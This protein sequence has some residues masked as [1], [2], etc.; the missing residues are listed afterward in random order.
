[1]SISPCP[2][3][4]QPLSIMATHCPH[5]ARPGRYP[6]V[7]MASQAADVAAL[8]DRVQKAEARASA[9]GAAVN[10]Q[11]FSA[12][13]AG[14]KAV[15]ARPR[16][17][18]ERLASNDNQIYATYYQLIEA[19][20]RVPDDDRWDALRRVTDE[21]LFPGQKEKIHFAALTLDAVGVLNYGACQ[22]TLR[23]PMIAHRASVFEEN[24]V[25]FMEK[26]Q[27]KLTEAPAAAVGFRAPWADRAKVCVAKLADEIKP[28]TTPAMHA[29]LLVHQGATP[30][31]DRFVEIH[32]W[33]P[34]TIRSF[35]HV[36]FLRSKDRKKLH[37]SDERALQAQLAKLGVGFEVRP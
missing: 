28:A 23:T 34:M 29:S 11:D 1:M 3:C 27:V 37:K 19:E 32:A 25:V 5:C 36:V 24:T 6:N 30:A 12:A 33:G 8:D 4:A 31:E 26:H 14:S 35:E 7:L 13:L 9:R 20:A 16:G 21:A 17:E 18:L 15:I 22:M 2:D 10:V